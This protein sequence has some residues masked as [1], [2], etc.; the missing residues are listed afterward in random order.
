MLTIYCHSVL[1]RKI[2]Y[3]YVLVSC[4]GVNLR[5]E[6]MATVVALRYLLRNIRC[7]KSF[8]AT[9]AVVEQGCPNPVEQVSAPTNSERK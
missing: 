7:R 9:S 6:Q 4:G 1:I 8:S 2:N 5:D 3:K